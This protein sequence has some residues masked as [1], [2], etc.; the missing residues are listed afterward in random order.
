MYNVE[1]KTSAAQ[2]NTEI[3]ATRKALAALGASLSQFFRASGTGK[4]TD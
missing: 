2:L 3:F 1:H 4:T